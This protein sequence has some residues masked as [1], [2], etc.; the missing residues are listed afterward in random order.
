MIFCIKN[1]RELSAV[2]DD[3]VDARRVE[4]LSENLSTGLST[5]VV[6]VLK[7]PPSGSRQ[8]DRDF[9]SFINPTRRKA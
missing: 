8:R 6:A 7:F 5:S 2:R 3:V 1:R 4:L 9:G